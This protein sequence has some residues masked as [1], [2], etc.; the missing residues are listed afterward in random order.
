MPELFEKIR[1]DELK[2]TYKHLAGSRQQKIKTGELTFFI[3]AD[4]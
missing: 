1:V 3:Y 2:D 4:F